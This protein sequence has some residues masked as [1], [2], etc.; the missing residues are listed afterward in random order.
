MGA[1]LNIDHEDGPAGLQPPFTREQ[2]QADVGTVL[3]TVARFARWAFARSDAD[4]NAVLLRLLGF[5]GDREQ[6][7]LGYPEVEWE[8]DGFNYEMVATTALAEDVE[9]LYDLAY[10]GH[11]DT[12]VQDL[13]SES[14]PSWTSRVLLD[15]S[16]SAFAAE[17]NEYSRC[18]ESIHRCLQVYETAH[19]RLILER[20]EEDDRFMDWHGPLLQGL[21]IRQMSLLSGMTE[22]SLRTMA[23]P[24]RKNPLKTQ[25]DGKN[26]YVGVDDA[27]AWLITKGRY[28]PIK[29]TSRG[30]RLDLTRRSFGST[31]ELLEAMDQRVRYL[32]SEAQA[33][34]ARSRIEAISPTLLVVGKRPHLR[35]DEDSLDDA[36]LMT[37]LGDA[38]GVPGALL[39]LRSAEVKAKQRL[40]SLER[41]I[42]RLTA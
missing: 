40:R 38:L 39:A 25:S 18:A 4:T 37:R 21:S 6:P 19:A 12:D 2:L 1:N 23:S 27:K 42:Q 13:D 17:W 36:K 8:S 14:T 28:V 35:L 20:I 31:D 41:Q 29:Y 26:T 5:P 3:L 15:L 32:L 9:K 22:A 30:G 24:R 11:I 33:D 16:R 34:E 10:F 7:N